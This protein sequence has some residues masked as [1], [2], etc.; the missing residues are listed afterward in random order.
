MQSTCIAAPLAD[1]QLRQEFELVRVGG[2]VRV[3]LSCLLNFKRP[4]SLAARSS[5]MLPGAVGP[6]P[7]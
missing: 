2:N 4:M 1:A 5:I 3:I 7:I 6:A